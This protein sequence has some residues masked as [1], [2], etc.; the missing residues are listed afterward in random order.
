MKKILLAISI[1]SSAAFAV[2]ADT[3]TPD[4]ESDTPFTICQVLATCD[5]ED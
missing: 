5:N 1:L 4:K 2:N 3:E